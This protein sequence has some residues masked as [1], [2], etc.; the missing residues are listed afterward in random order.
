MLPRPSRLAATAALVVV[1]PLTACGQADDTPVGTEAPLEVTTPTAA[2]KEEFKVEHRGEKVTTDELTGEPVE[3]PAMELTYK[4]QGTSSA[5]NGG[6]V[7]VVAVTNRSDVPVPVEAIEQ[8]TLRYGSGSNKTEA[9]PQS[10]EAAGVD[11]IGID[12]PLAPFAT[13]NAKYAF[14]VRPGNLGNAEFTIGNVTFS[15]SL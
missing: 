5:P 7:V 6:T 4:W 2:P 8:P 12:E 14:D 1:L 10:A 15:G 3:D 11:I 13:V 9:R